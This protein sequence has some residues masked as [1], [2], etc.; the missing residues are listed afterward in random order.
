MSS[1]NVSKT[2]RSQWLFTKSLRFELFYKAEPEIFNSVDFLSNNEWCKAN[3]DILR[4]NMPNKV[5]K[6]PLLSYTKALRSSDIGSKTDICVHYSLKNN[7]GRNSIDSMEKCLLFLHQMNDLNIEEVLLVSGSGK[8]KKSVN[9]LS[10]L[11]YLSKHNTIDRV[12][13]MKTK[14]GI[15]Y[16]CYFLDEDD[17]NVEDNRL[18][19]KLNTGLVNSIWLQFGTDI[20]KLENSI[21][22][23]RK[24]SNVRIIGSLFIPSKQLLARFKFRPW[25]G[26]F[27]SEKYLNDINDAISITKS[28]ISI[29]FKYNI[30]IVIE[31]AIKN[32]DEL[33]KML[34][35]FEETEAVEHVNDNSIQLEEVKRP[36]LDT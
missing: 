24:Y 23:I 29:Y 21:I 20:N 1:G 8:V 18:L 10:F 11:E 32:E 9:S 4:V 31:S 36:K 17:Q 16:N 26:V 6:D 7:I 34:S 22:N 13:Q 28:I 15:A 3:L 12:Q 30:E 33:N 2:S 27:L 14:I 35:L 5:R 25:N 19:S